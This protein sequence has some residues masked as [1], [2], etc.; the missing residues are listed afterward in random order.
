MEAGRVRGSV[1]SS[2]VFIRSDVLREIS[3]V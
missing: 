2:D 3:D 1:A